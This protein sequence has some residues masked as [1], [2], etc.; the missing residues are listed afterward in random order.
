M[1][2]TL[3]TKLVL[4]LLCYVSAYAR[5]RVEPHHGHALWDCSRRFP[6]LGG[7]M[8]V[9]GVE[10]FQGLYLLMVHGAQTSDL[11]KKFF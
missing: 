3:R 10:P 6:R 7:V 9:L 8:S 5:S 1:V 2:T 4:C 11:K